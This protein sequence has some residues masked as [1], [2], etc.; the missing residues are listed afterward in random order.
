MNPIDTCSKDCCTHV[1][2]VFI[3]TKGPYYGLKYETQYR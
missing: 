2:E 1:V 3:H